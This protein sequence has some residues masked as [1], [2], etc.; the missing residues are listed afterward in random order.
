MEKKDL[1]AVRKR[2]PAAAAKRRHKVVTPAKAGA[3]RLAKVIAGY[4]ASDSYMYAPL[5]SAPPSLP[6][7]P[8]ASS[9]APSATPLISTPEKEITGAKIQRLFASYIH[10]LEVSVDMFLELCF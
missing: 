9:V 3:G 10:C 8:P 5:I 7:P 1:L 4:L 2:L 6:P